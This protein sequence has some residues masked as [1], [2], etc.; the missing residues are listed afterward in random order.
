MIMSECGNSRYHRSDYDPVIVLSRS[1]SKHYIDI[2][3]ASWHL[4]LPTTQ[5]FVCVIFVCVIRV[6]LAHSSSDD[7]EDIFVTHIIFI[8]KSEVDL[9]HYIWYFLWLCAWCGCTIIC[10]RFHIYIYIY[11]PGKLENVVPL[12]PC[13][14]MMCANNRVHFGPM[15]VFVCLHST[16]PHY[17]HY[18]L[19]VSNF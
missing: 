11:I 9:S 14:L 15:V 16:R 18:H 19:K 2:T 1:R 3:R 8:I 10:F 4:I 6:K 5:L 17:H 13:S 12:S 7:R